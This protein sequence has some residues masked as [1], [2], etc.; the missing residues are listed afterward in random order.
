MHGYQ[1]GAVFGHRWFG[2]RSP[3]GTV[4]CGH[5]QSRPKLR[6]GRSG[7]ASCRQICAHQ[8]WDQ[9]DPQGA[10]VALLLPH[11]PLHSQRPQLGLVSQQQARWCCSLSAYVN[12][13]LSLDS[14]LGWIKPCMI[15]ALVHFKT[16]L[17]YI[18]IPM[19]AL[20]MSRAQTILGRR[21]RLELAGIFVPLLVTRR[22]ECTHHF[23]I[24]QLE[25]CHLQ[26][27]RKASFLTNPRAFTRLHAAAGWRL[28]A[29]RGLRR[30]DFSLSH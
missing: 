20:G 4:G 18:W 6:G 11:A 1:L 10:V 7:L 14:S 17:I 2:H 19:G 23:N 13:D 3:A 24:W 30:G 15:V 5:W 9:R 16:V 8:A 26:R 29:A 12:A 28:H 21:E 22:K 25:V 27:I